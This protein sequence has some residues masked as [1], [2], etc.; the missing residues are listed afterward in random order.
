MTNKDEAML[1]LP[2][3]PRRLVLFEI[4]ESVC[5]NSLANQSVILHPFCL[6]AVQF[7]LCNE[8]DLLDITRPV[9]NDSLEEGDQSLKLEAAMD[10]KY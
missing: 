3:P 4:V 9:G 2:P 8:V 7:P 1:P 5:K 10:M 6:P